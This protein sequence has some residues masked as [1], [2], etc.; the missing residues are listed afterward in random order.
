MEHQLTTAHRVFTLH[1]FNNCPLQSKLH[2]GN[3]K[4]GPGTSNL[5]NLDL[6]Q[7]LATDLPYWR[8]YLLERNKL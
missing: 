1:K 7:K 5:L 4:N 3:S 2:Y 6:A 8:N